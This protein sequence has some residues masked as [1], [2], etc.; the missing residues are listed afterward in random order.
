MQCR[1]PGSRFLSKLFCGFSTANKRCRIISR[2]W[3][4]NHLIQNYFH[5]KTFW[6]MMKQAMFEF[7]QL[8]NATHFCSSTWEFWSW[9]WGLVP[10]YHW[11][12]LNAWSYPLNCFLFFFFISKSTSIRHNFSQ[13]TVISQWHEYN[14]TEKCNLQQQ[15]TQRVKLSQDKSSWQLWCTFTEG[16]LRQKMG[17]VLLTFHCHFHKG[18]L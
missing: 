17:N 5:F 8:C 10:K 13:L 18:F 16:K 6:D 1:N 12:R 15:K 11:P 2:F 3:H 7:S 14:M 9:R 4:T